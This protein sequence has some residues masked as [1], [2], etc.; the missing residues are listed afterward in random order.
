VRGFK[1]GAN[2]DSIQH[3]GTDSTCSHKVFVSEAARRG[4]DI[5][6]INIGKEFLHTVPREELL[7][8]A[9]EPDRGFDFHLLPATLPLL[10]LIKGFEKF[11]PQME[12]LHC[13]FPSPRLVNASRALS[14]KFQ[15]VTEAVFKLTP[16]SVDP[17]LCF[18]HD[19]GKLVLLMTRNI[20]DLKLTGEPQHIR[21][22]LANLQN[23][24]GELKVTYNRLSIV[25]CTTHNTPTQ[26][27]SRLTK[28]SMR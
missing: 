12:V 16:S 17:E 3:A 15:Q 4:W 26:K 8:L 28:T 1:D 19:R 24:F 18:R 2:G 27:R 22:V 5:C 11:D 10:G 9:G 14:I 7:T 13:D 6:T 21:V 25:E 20:D 23:V